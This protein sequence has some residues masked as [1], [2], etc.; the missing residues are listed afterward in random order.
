MRLEGVGAARAAAGRVAGLFSRCDHARRHQGKAAP[1]PATCAGIRPVSICPQ[2]PQCPG[3]LSSLRLRTR[4]PNTGAGLRPIRRIVLSVLSFC[5]RYLEGIG[6][7][8]GWVPLTSP[9]MRVRNGAN[10]RKSRRCCKGVVSAARTR[11][12]R[13][14]RPG[15]SWEISC[16]GTKRLAIALVNGVSTR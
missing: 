16:T 7:V 2:C 4:K 10:A 13:G 15:P 14:N 11:Q 8:P 6:A 5:R 9:H 1:F 3:V 12:V